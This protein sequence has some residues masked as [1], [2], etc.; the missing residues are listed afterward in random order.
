M[1]GAG[2]GVGSFDAKKVGPE[3]SN[4]SVLEMIG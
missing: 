2:E 4:L 3:A 1:V